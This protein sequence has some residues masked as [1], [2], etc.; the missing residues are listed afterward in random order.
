MRPL[1]FLCYMS[2]NVTCLPIF[3]SFSNTKLISLLD[4]HIHLRTMSNFTFYLIM[5]HFSNFSQIENVTRLKS[6][7]ANCSERKLSSITTARC[8]SLIPQKTANLRLRKQ[9]KSN[10]TLVYRY[11][12]KTC[13]EINLSWNVKGR[14]LRL[15]WCM[16]S[17]SYR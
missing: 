16:A 17:S 6:L 2:L 5:K 4:Q 11:F 10:P 7:L 12:A 1:K 14:K 13:F 9:S 8:S 3:I 15:N